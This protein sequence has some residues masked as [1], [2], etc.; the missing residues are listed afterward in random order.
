MFASPFQFKVKGSPKQAV[1]GVTSGVAD[2]KLITSKKLVYAYEVDQQ[3][4]SFVLIR[5]RAPDTVVA[6]IFCELF[7][8]ATSSNKSSQLDPLKYS[9]R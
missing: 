1:T 5:K 7:T 8:P 2:F 3:S 4:F 9:T 6:L